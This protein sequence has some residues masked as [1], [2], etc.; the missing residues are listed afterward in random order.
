MTQ[1]QETKRVKGRHNFLSRACGFCLR[2]P[3]PEKKR[4][5][6]REEGEVGVPAQAGRRARERNKTLKEKEESVLE[7]RRSSLFL[8]GPPGNGMLPWWGSFPRG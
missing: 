3:A 6:K 7:S 5:K 1:E 4:V 2:A 8:S